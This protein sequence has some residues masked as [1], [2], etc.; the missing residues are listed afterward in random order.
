VLADLRFSGD[1]AAARLAGKGSD[2]NRLAVAWDR[3][4]A[5]W[6]RPVVGMMTTDLESVIDFL[7]RERGLE[8]G[9][10]SVTAKDD[11]PLAL[12]A[13]LAACRD[14]RITALDVDFTGRSYANS[15]SQRSSAQ[16]LPLVCNIL[17]YGDIPEWATLL[18]DRRVTL[19]H[20]PQ[21]ESSRHR[22]ED[23]FAKFGAATNLQLAE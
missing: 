10:V 3:D 4:G 21:P 18:G 2:A 1:Y 11:A 16:D 14:S 8:A 22:L 9:V 6:G 19:R 12:A 7:T 20:L 5:L 13:L 23:V 15:A 17:Q